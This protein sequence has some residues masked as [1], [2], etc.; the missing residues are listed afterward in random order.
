MATTLADYQILRDSSFRLVG[1]GNPG[2]VNPTPQG[3]TNRSFKFTPP[4]DI[5]ISNST[6]RGPV[7]SFKI[8][9]ARD[10]ELRVTFGGAQPV[11]TNFDAS[12]TRG[13]W[14]CFKY[15]Q[16]MHNRRD[17]NGQ[18]D[19]VFQCFAGEINIS[20]IVVWYQRLRD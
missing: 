6:S 15:T 7:L 9:P 11:F 5:F 20:D 8:R 3:A 13:Y 2:S 10:S 12:H 16:S 19:V 17:E 4:A 18:L 14:E 1:S